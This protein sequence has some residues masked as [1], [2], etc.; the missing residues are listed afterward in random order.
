[1]AE[2]A[3]GVPPLAPHHGQL[4]CHVMKRNE[5]L[6]IRIEPALQA[7]LQRLRDERHVNVSAWL[8]GLITAELERAFPLPATDRN[9]EPRTPTGSWDDPLPRLSYL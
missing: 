6:Q 8:R 4:K 9:D 5:V 2:P 3:G 1:M 7:G